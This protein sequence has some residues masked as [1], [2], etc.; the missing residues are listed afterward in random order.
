MDGLR[1]AL[2]R[3]CLCGQGIALEQHHFGEMFVQHPGGQQAGQAGTEDNGA[4]RRGG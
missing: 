2:A 3:G 4:L 1:R